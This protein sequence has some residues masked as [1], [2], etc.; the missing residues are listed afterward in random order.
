LSSP[1]VGIPR[2]VHCPLTI[3]VLINCVHYER[4]TYSRHRKAIT[5]G[6]TDHFPDAVTS[7]RFPVQVCFLTAVIRTGFFNFTF[8]RKK[9]SFTGEKYCDECVCLS[10][11]I[12]EKLHVQ[13]S[14]HFLY[15]LNVA[16]AR[17][18][19]DDNA[20]LRT[21]S[22]V[23]DVMFSNNRPGKGDADR[24]YTQSDSLVGSTG[25]EVLC[26]RLPC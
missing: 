12:S 3:T 10:A 21:S 4:W 26:L 22:S 11:R 6:R 24:A 19:S 16:V 8:S 14:R 15:V 1:R 5:R 25:G 7:L 18:S 9:N 13:T 17:S 2:V 20:M 23:D